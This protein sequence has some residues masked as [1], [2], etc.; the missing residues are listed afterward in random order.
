VLFCVLF[1]CKCLPPPGDNSIAVNKYIISIT[2]KFTRSAKPIRIT[3]VQISGVLPYVSIGATSL[4]LP[5]F[6]QCTKQNKVYSRCCCITAATQHDYT[7]LS[8]KLQKCVVLTT[9]VTGKVTAV[10]MSVNWQPYY[11]SKRSLQQ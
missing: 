2:D 8:V 10:S 3:S 11:D 6:T 5:Y 1:V 9:A 4:H 7:P